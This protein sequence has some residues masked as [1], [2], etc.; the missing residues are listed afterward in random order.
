[1]EGSLSFHDKILLEVH[2]EATDEVPLIL[3][4]RMEEAEGLFS[5]LFRWRLRWSLWIV[6]QRNDT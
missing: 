3:K 2:I 5:R 4:E 1:M 6:G